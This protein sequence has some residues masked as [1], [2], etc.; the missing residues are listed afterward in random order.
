M[1]QFSNHSIA[2]SRGRIL[3]KASVI[4]TLSIVVTLQLYAIFTGKKTVST[5]EGV[6]FV[7]KDDTQKNAGHGLPKTRE[8]IKRELAALYDRQRQKIVEKS[9]KLPLR[10]ALANAETYA[11]IQADLI[12]SL[13]VP[14]GKLYKQLG[15]DNERLQKLRRLLAE[16]EIALLE[17]YELSREAKIPIDSN[18]LNTLRNE[19]DTAIRDLLGDPAFNVYKNYEATLGARN[20]VN[21]LESRLSYKTQPLSDSQYEALVVELSRLR[22]PDVEPGRETWVGFYRLQISGDTLEIAKNILTPQQFSTYEAEYERQERSIAVSIKYSE[23]FAT[24]EKKYRENIKAK[25]VNKE[26]AP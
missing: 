7:Q 16:K 9:S 1:K 12:Q 15:L 13:D 10:A 2:I 6:A 22:E 23:K 3:L 4:C 11:V 21:A 5:K 14:Y 20:H 8:Q 26:S 24:A 25:L 17:G 19:P 18:M